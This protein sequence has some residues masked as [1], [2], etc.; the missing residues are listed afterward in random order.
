M[1]KKITFVDFFAGAG[2]FSE[3]FL[4]ASTDT[5]DFDFLLASDINENC[6]L[7]HLVRYNYQL[8]LKTK[9]LRKS[10]SD[11]DFIDQLLENLEGQSVDVICGGPPCQSFSLAGRRR[12]H[13]RKDD[14]FSSYLRVIARLQ[15]KYFVM[16][17]VTGLL[18]KEKGAFKRR[19]LDGIASII[20]VHRLPDLQQFTTKLSKLVTSESKTIA[21]LA[22]RIVAES[23]YQRGLSH[24][25]S[26]SVEIVSKMFRDVVGS[27]FT[28]KD[29]KTNRELLTIRHAINILRNRSE[30]E[31]LAKATK[32]F[33]HIAD[34]D[35]DNFVDTIDNFIDH[36]AIENVVETAVVACNALRVHNENFASLAI[37]MQTFGLSVNECLTRLSLFADVHNITAEF[38]SMTRNLQ[39]YTCAG[40]K[41]LLASNYG[42]PQDRRRVVFIGCRNDVPLIENVP[43]CVRDGEKVTVSEAISDLDTLESGERNNRYLT[44]ASLTTSRTPAS[45]V[46]ENGLSYSEWSRRGRVRIKPVNPPTFF[47]SLDDFYAGIGVI[48]DLHNHE[49]SNHNAT[50]VKRY[51]AMVACGDYDSLK[52]QLDADIASE[53]RDYSVLKPDGQSPTVMTIA[54]DFVH[55]RVPRAITVRE[56]AR[57]QS[58]DDSF[59]FQGKRTTGG[60]RRKEEIPQCTLVGNAVPPLL[61]KA[62]ADVIGAH[63]DSTTD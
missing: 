30:L 57:L 38:C 14:L 18:T 7:T 56:M 9:F 26:S 8:G 15:P 32:H 62:I 35:Q 45:V 11:D 39:L 20:D 1:K 54:D 10:I 53:K 49:A 50:V 23:Q 25:E 33:K 28:Y 21:L 31:K 6:E 34:I 3:G 63:I 2:G 37:A 44:P 41:V 47:T 24:D 42:V 5:T 27:T 48:E 40:P 55:Y 58:F 16:E 22:N 12:K 61:A 46:D 19:I 59:V 60:H 36:L 17:N 52:G 4:Q 29:S 51:S 43:A 13:D